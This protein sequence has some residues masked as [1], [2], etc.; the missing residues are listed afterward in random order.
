MKKMLFG[1]IAFIC[2]TNFSLGQ[3]EK[4]DVLSEEF[5]KAGV[6]YIVKGK[7]NEGLLFSFETFN[8]FYFRNKKVNLKRYTIELKK[9]TYFLNDIE[10]SGID[11]LYSAY[12]KNNSVYLSTPYLKGMIEEFGDK[13]FE[14]QNV[15]VLLLFVRERMLEEKEKTTFEMFKRNKK[16]CAAGDTYY[17]VGWGLSTDSSQSH[18]ANVIKEAASEG[19]FNGCAEISKDFTTSCAKGNHICVST[20]AWCCKK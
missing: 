15:C 10:N 18:L 3:T 7:T 13:V 1:L 11:N 4:I 9:N 12:I 2:I 8:R 17:S 16:G 14:D 20:F 5:F 19:A 6:N